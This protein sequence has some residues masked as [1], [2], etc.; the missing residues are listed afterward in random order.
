IITKSPRS[1][2]P[3]ILIAPAGSRLEPLI[4]AFSAPASTIILPIGF[5]PDTIHFLRAVRGLVLEMNT[6]YLTFPL[7]KFFN[8]LDKFPL[9][10][11]QVAPALTAIFAASILV[12]IPPEPTEDKASPA[13]FTISVVISLISQ[14][15]FADLSLEGLEV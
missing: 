6:E 14:I 2:S 12:F 4:N 5:T 10:I 8:G 3:V 11:T 7:S 1:N 15:C 9:V 13:I